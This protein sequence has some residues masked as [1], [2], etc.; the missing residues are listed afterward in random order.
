MLIIEKYGGSII[1]D[2]S[3]LKFIGNKI[4][5][6]VKNSKDKYIIILSA[7]KG[8]TNYLINNLKDLNISIDTKDASNYISFG[9]RETCYLLNHYINKEINSYYL[10]VNEL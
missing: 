10:N 1:K 6:K 2:I 3:D 4:V 9:E 8:K 7:F 5:E